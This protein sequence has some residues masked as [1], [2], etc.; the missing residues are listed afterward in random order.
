MLGLIW[1]CFQSLHFHHNYILDNK[2]TS[3]K[4]IIPFQTKLFR[5]FKFYN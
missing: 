1:D 3:H 2:L 5:C 4:A